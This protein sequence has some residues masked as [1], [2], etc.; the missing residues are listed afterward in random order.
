M[1]VEPSWEIVI[2]DNGSSDGTTQMLTALKTELPVL[3]ASERR[4]GKSRA[5]NAGLKH[6]RGDILLFTDDDV[7]PDPNWLVGLYN[8]AANFPSA[9]IFGGRIVVPDG[10][11]PAWLKK[12]VNLRTMLASEQDL[13]DEI[14]WFSRGQYPTGPN[15]AVRRRLLDGGSY[16]WPVNLGP[17]T[18]VPLGDERAFLMQFSDWEADDRLFVPDCVVCHYIG[19]RQ[20]KFSSALARCFLG[21]YAAGMIGRTG[22]ASSR[23]TAGDSLRLVRRRLRGVASG[24][25]L[26]CVGTR[27]AGVVL[28]AVNPW[29][30]ILYP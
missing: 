3:V 14:C 5:M 1:P 19:G 16:G 17:G 18:S 12:S 26:F 21:G 28:G 6:A 25:E 4:P 10:L 11:M 9:N 13:G 20:L 15:L 23:K 27:A 8:A 29:G 30:R 2:V 7:I 24:R 22:G